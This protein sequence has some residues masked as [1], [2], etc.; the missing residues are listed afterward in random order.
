M[1][2]AGERVADPPLVAGGAVAGYSVDGG[3]DDPGRVV[4]GDC[5]GRLIAR[6]GLVRSSVLGWDAGWQYLV[7]GTLDGVSVTFAFLAFR[8]VQMKKAPDWQSRRNAATSSPRSAPARPAGRRLPCDRRP[9]PAESRAA[10]VGHARSP[11][12]SFPHTS[13]LGPMGR[14]RPTPIRMRRS[15]RSS[16]RRSAG[17]CSAAPCCVGRCS[18]GGCFVGG[19]FVG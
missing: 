2:R 19:C 14:F 13:N 5:A 6:S 16:G 18:L 7:P 8:A 17:R 1:R 3:R 9:A 10:S 11:A 15:P 4:L 12:F